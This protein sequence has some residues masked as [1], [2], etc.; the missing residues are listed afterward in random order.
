MK[1]KIWTVGLIAIAIVMACSAARAQ[2]TVTFTSIDQ[3]TFNNYLS[4]AAWVALVDTRGLAGFSDPSLAAGYDGPDANTTSVSLTNGDGIAGLS[5]DIVS[6]QFGSTGGTASESVD[7]LTPIIGLAIGVVSPSQSQGRTAA[8]SDLYIG[9]N[10][11]GSVANTSSSTFSGMLC[12]FQN[13]SS[14]FD[15]L[16]T[17]TTGVTS[18]SQIYVIGITA[19]PVPEPSSLALIGLGGIGL[20]PFLR[21]RK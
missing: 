8:V 2:G 7:S 20:I 16:F 21:R 12:D 4:Q 13:P 19:D 10:Y 14:L 17:L 11:Q 5:V 18:A 3:A 1:T 6:G 15:T 9:A